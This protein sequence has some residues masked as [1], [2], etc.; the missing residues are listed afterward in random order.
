[1]LPASLRLLLMTP[2]VAIRGWYTVRTGNELLSGVVLT[3]C[4]LS[5]V[6]LSTRG[7]NEVLGCGWT[8]VMGDVT[9][10]GVF[11]AGEDEG[12]NVDATTNVHVATLFALSNAEPLLDDNSSWLIIFCILLSLY[13]GKDDWP[14]TWMLQ[15]P[16]S[17]CRPL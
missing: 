7:L 16:T 4:G 5:S 8:W 2:T 14:D 11:G 1:M 17:L 10:C 13:C 6:G 3:E 15:L 12:L 9:K